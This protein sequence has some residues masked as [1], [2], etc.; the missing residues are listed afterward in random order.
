MPEI[1]ATYRLQLHAGFP[2]SAARALGPYLSRLGVSHIHCSPVLRSR[3]GS[4][5]GYDVVDP[6]QVD[7]DLGSESDLEDLHAA[8]AARGMGIVLDLVPNHMAASSENPP[9]KRPR[10]CPRE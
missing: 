9:A 3:R 7:P 8:L 4:T 1:R 10:R 6:R 5:H 2:F